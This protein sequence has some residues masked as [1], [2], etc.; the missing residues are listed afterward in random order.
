MDLPAGR[1]DRRKTLFEQKSKARFAAIWGQW[2]NLAK[3]AVTNTRR[4]PGL[5]CKYPHG[6]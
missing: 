2:T 3:I 1:D 5:I 4:L 6:W